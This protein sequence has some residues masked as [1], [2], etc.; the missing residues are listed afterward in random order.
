MGNHSEDLKKYAVR[1][2]AGDQMLGSGVL[3]KPT[4]CEHNRLYV[5]TA[6]HFIKYSENFEV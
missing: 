6:A 1:I 5:F 4:D 2:K 3:W